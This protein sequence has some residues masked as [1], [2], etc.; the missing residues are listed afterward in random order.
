[1]E[2]RG[3]DHVSEIIQALEERGLHVEVDI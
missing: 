2:T 1:L 3:Q